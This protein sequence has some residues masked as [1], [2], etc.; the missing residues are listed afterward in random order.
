MLGA[1]ALASLVFLSLQFF[2]IQKVCQYCLAVDLLMIIIF[3]V[4]LN[5]EHRP[6]TIEIQA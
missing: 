2:V 5:I 6:H 3:L 4:D 1:G